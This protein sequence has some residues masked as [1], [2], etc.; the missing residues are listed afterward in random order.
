[1]DLQHC[2]FVENSA[3]FGSAILNYGL[4]SPML[5]DC[6]FLANN[7]YTGTVECDGQLIGMG[8][9]ISGTCTV[10]RCTFRDNTTQGTGGGILCADSQSTLVSGCTFLGNTA[11]VGGGAISAGVHSI[12]THCVF[13]R[14]R[15]YA[16]GALLLNSH[17]SVDNC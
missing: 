4:A 17:S 5:H 14:N 16:G 11:D 8:S 12:I 9:V 13:G 10:I 1:P 3:E 15:S 2:S 6:E 7:S